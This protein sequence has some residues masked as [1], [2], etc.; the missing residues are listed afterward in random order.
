[1]R[2]IHAL[3]PR[4]A[5]TRKRVPTIR[6]T[7]GLRTGKTKPVTRGKTSKARS[8]DWQPQRREALWKNSFRAFSNITRRGKKSGG[9]EQMD[10]RSVTPLGKR[11]PPPAQATQGISAGRSVR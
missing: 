9:P 7:V 2:V 3:P 4:I 11:R 8:L 5:G 1:M 6:V 10:R